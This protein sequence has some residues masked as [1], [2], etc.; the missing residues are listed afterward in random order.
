MSEIVGAREEPPQ[1]EEAFDLVRSMLSSSS[2]NAAAHS[3]GGFFGG[4]RA[5]KQKLVEVALPTRPQAPERFLS[6]QSTP[7]ASSEVSDVGSLPP[8]PARKPE[9]GRKPKAKKPKYSGLKSMFAC[10]GKAEHRELTTLKSP[11]SRATSGVSDIIPDVYDEPWSEAGSQMG[12]PRA[13][14]QM[15]TPSSSSAR[16]SLGVVKNSFKQQFSFAQAATNKYF[17]EA[18]DL[19]KTVIPVAMAKSVPFADNINPLLHG[20][21]LYV[22][23]VEARG[24]LAMDLNGFSDPYAKITVGTQSVM[25][26]PQKKTLS[27]RWDET[28]VFPIGGAD[29]WQKLHMSVILWDEDITSADD[30]MGEFRWPLE[31]APCCDSAPQGKWVQLL[32][33]KPSSHSRDHGEAF[34]VW[35]AGTTDD[36]AL[37]TA[38]L[39]DKAKATKKVQSAVYQEP[40]ISFVAVK[41]SEIKN[42]PGWC[43]KVVLKSKDRSVGSAARAVGTSILKSIGLKSSKEKGGGEEDAVEGVV[44]KMWARVSLGQQVEVSGK[45]EAEGG[46]AVARWEDCKLFFACSRPYTSDIKVEFFCSHGRRSEKIGTLAI[47]IGSKMKRSSSVMHETSLNLHTSEGKWRDLDSVEKMEKGDLNP[48]RANVGV[49][50]VETAADRGSL[51][52]EDMGTLHL[53][54]RGA[55]LPQEVDSYVMMHFGKTWLR[56]R[57]INQTKRPHW[58]EEFTVRF[59]DPS[60]VLVIGVFADNTEK[61]GARVHNKLKMSDA[62]MGKVRLQLS[63][64]DKGVTHELTLPL[65]R[66]GKGKLVSKAG[67]IQLSA[68]VV[69]PLNTA[70]MKQLLAPPLPV[71]VYKAGIARDK[72]SQNK[73]VS[74]SQMYVAQWM[75]ASIP[76]V[77]PKVCMEL[78]ET[79]HTDVDFSM[80]LFKDYKEK[81][82]VFW[83][84]FDRPKRLITD[85][86]GWESPA[87]SLSFIGGC[88]L[89]IH[90]LELM[91]VIPPLALAARLAL[92]WKKRVTAG[93]ARVLALMPPTEKKKEKKKDD[94]EEEPDSNLNPYT[95][96]KRKY[97]HLMQVSSKVQGNLIA[98]VSML[99]RVESVMTW[100]DERITGG[101][102]LGC[103]GG[104]LALQVVG[105]KLLASA[106]VIKF[107]RPP[108]FRKKFHKPDS[109][110]NVLRAV[111]NP[112]DHLIYL[113]NRKGGGS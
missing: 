22:R 111:P 82:M 64:L 108:R 69:C 97:D 87:L 71:E 13:G 93:E 3:T 95:A 30:H 9:S 29:R 11:P 7:P 48:P 94:D 63:L 59:S 14:S 112:T 39:P 15:G 60:P 113:F 18:K 105:Y 81:F 44:G 2:Y 102:L 42:L 85:V 92:N 61:A 45:V 77:D 72:K 47:P 66:A 67:Y 96:M 16:A 34:V 8:S 23:I 75:E 91:F 46:T 17:N 58:E 5:H 73:L 51:V 33:S 52:N 65:L 80:P 50:F 68:R 35:W 103:V 24:L 25:T 41:I 26:K 31:D 49:Q 106:W 83:H 110:D 104:L 36:A 76:P 57:R 40:A 6:Y 38:I 20:R 99:E 37:D 74:A 1:A 84:N 70:F 43:Q 19:I 28:F 90:N 62:L 21:Y 79:L 32:G 10:L 88:L 4:K 53:M 55:Q 100:Q 101:L 78:I 109:V 86:K 89:V 27:P 98:V 56:T 107:F 12:T 54:V